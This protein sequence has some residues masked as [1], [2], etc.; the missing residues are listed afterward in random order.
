MLRLRGTKIDLLVMPM[1]MAT[2]AFADFLMLSGNYG[3]QIDA[4]WSDGDFNEDG[5]YRFL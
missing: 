2:V 4:I 5:K 1:V 3:K